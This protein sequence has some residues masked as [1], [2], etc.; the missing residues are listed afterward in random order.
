[1]ARKRKIEAG[2]VGGSISASIWKLAVPMMVS[3]ILQ[4]LFSMVDLYFVGRLGYQEV[5]ALSIAGTVVAI[6][7]MLVQGIGVGTLALVAHYV[8]QKQ[9]AKADEVL[10]QTLLLAGLG[11][12]IMYGVRLFLV[13]P[14]L[15]LFGA[16]GEVL[17]LAADYLRITF[18]WS[19][20]IFFF[21]GI[22][23]ALRGS[24]DARTPLWALLIANIL[25]I[26]LD[27][28]FIMGYGF[29]PSLGVAGSAAAT[30]ASRGLG[31]VYL[32][33]HLLFGHSTIHF[34]IRWLK[35]DWTLMGEIIRVGFFASLQVLIREVSFLFLMRLVASF[36]D[37]TLAAYG[38]GSR[39]RMMVMVPGFA[40][41]GAAA[42]L[43]GQNLGA[44]QPARAS[45]STWGA[46]GYYEMLVVPIAVLF[47]LGA[48]HI[49]GLFN[50]N[51][52]VIQLGSRF[53]RYLA[54][55]LPFLAFSLVFSQAMNGAGD[56]VT[57]TIVNAVGQ[58]VFRVPLAY[59]CALTF[60]MGQEGIWVGIN[61]S[62]IVQGLGMVFIFRSGCWMTMHNRHR[63]RMGLEP[64]E[65]T[66]D[67]G[68]PSSGAEQAL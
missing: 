29:F 4:D 23:H 9:H 11:A 44:R 30:V 25:N 61:G 66:T 54:V 56:T 37:T 31:L 67:A 14:L 52:E 22:D 7:M 18:G 1:M 36:G 13:V 40:F 60:G 51:P 64:L 58:L 57:P 65:M 26:V 48:P 24:G 19:S 42:V 27:P 32:F 10:G 68:L 46:V 33:L 47:I 6:L 55:T 45:K 50:D 20:V 17:N 15:E 34:K 43:T 38:I 16:R 21:V 62:D 63:G 2:L 53:L 41:A 12:V 5:A 39:I 35:P 3:G 28:I 49:V 8:G 59:L